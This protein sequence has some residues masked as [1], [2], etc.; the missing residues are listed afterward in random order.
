M[1]DPI[2]LLQEIEEI[3]KAEG[4]M[5]SS[6]PLPNEKGLIEKKRKLHGNLDRIVKYWVSL[7]THLS[8]VMVM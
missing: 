4:E 2:V 7:P 8:D 5:T 1:K 6:E 3:E